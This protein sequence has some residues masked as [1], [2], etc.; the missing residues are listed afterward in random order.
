MIPPRIS[1]TEIN[2]EQLREV[3]A[4]RFQPF[5][6]AGWVGFGLVCGIGGEM[7]F[8]RSVLDFRDVVVSRGDLIFRSQTTYRTTIV[9]MDFDPSRRPKSLHS[10]LQ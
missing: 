2:G 3:P 10:S 8:R 6:G 4:V 7:G 5:F 1:Q 9:T